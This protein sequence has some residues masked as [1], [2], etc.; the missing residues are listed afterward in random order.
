MRATHALLV[1]C[2]FLGTISQAIADDSQWIQRQ[3][4]IHRVWAQKN[5][6]IQR[7]QS[8]LWKEAMQK[9]FA[10]LRAENER[11]KAKHQQW[12]QDQWTTW[13]ED[14]AHSKNE[15]TRSSQWARANYDNIMEHRRHRDSRVAGI[16]KAP[17]M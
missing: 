10:W 15:L 3:R 4:E 9:N 2:T 14:S 13:K 12:R 17:P 5:W 16:Q 1:F 8:A 11:N 6:E 7:R